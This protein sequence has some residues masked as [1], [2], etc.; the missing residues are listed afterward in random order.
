MQ[1]RL[2]TCDNC[3]KER[4]IWKI[5]TENGGRKRLCRVCWNLLRPGK[6]TTRQKNIRPRSQKRTKEE[7]LYSAKRV[8]FLLENPMCQAKLAGC[9]LKSTEVHHRAGRMEE[10][11]LDIM[12]WLPTCR[13]CHDWV[14]THNPEAIE[15]GLSETR[16]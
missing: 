6:P 5:L 4:P 13:S 2:K 12:K 3:S 14:T 8:I 11:Y 7:K 16:Y 9:T 10:N 15:L 1:Q